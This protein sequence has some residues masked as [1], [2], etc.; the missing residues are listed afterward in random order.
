M[1]TGTGFSTTAA[2]NTVTFLGEAG[3]TDNAVVMTVSA[4]TAISLSVTVPSGAVTGKIQVAVNSVVAVSSDDFTVLTSVPP[5]DTDADGLIDIIR[6][7]R[8]W[9]R[10]ATTC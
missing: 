10:Y 1:I 6:H 3:A 9:M 7:L 5:T 8:S 4:A 2:D